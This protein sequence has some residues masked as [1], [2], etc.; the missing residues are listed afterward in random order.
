MAV[1]VAINGFGR[2]GRIA[3]RQMIN[4]PDFEIVALNGIKDVEMGAHLIKYDT[5]LGRFEFYKEVETTENS[6]IVC[7][8]EIKV[9]NAREAS[10]LP[11]KEVGAEIIIDCSGAYRKKDKAMEHINA[12]AKRVVISAPAGN[13]V[14]TIAYGVNHEVL[15]SDDIIVSAASCT[16]NC[17]AP[18]AKVLHQYAPIQSGIMTSVH[19]YTGDQKAVDGLHRKSDFRRARAAAG[20]I[21]PNSSGAASAIGLVIPELS[22][23]LTGSA[24]RVPVQTGSSTILVAAVRGKD[25]SVEG[26]NA[27][28]KAAA[29]E[30]LGY[31]EDEI[32]SSDVIG[33]T[34]G[35]IFDATQTMVIPMG[36]DLYQ[37]QVVA[38]YDNESGYTA[39]MIRTIRHIA[40]LMK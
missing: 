15:T 19:A 23:L 39:Q 27:A 6:I 4:D 40:G 30:T 24:Q 28:M 10:E 22:G 36:E 13:D 29:N 1:K 21:V 17:L 14:P 37:V 2:I 7:G 38:W 32:V 34:E 26:I 9:F 16:T 5:I 25:V 20:N 18:M 35:G 8:K 12:G 33:T 3:F 11:W 31:T